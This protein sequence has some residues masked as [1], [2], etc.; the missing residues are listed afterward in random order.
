M[1][2]AES[3][4]SS[5]WSWMPASKSSVGSLRP[6]VSMRR[7]RLSMRAMTLSRVVPSSRAT[8]AM[9]LRAKRLSRLDLPAL[10]WPINATMGSF[11]IRLFYTKNLVLK[12]KE[13]YLSIIA[14]M[15]EKVNR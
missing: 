14:Q 9:F 6:A 3:M 12:R 1:R 8:I 5:I 15:V 10:V 13:S 7:K 4:A 11:F 2:S